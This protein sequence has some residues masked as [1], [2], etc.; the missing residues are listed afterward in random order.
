MKITSMLIWFQFRMIPT[1][2][3]G[4]WPTAQHPARRRLR[5]MSSTA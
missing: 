3:C 5:L 2:G 1:S 4:G